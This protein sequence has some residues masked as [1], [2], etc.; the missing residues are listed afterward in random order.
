ENPNPSAAP[1]CGG[2]GEL[3]SSWNVEPGSSRRNT[4]TVSPVTPLYGSCGEPTTSAV[5]VTTTG[6]SESHGNGRFD[7]VP[8]S[9]RSNTRTGSPFTTSVRSRRATL[10][11]NIPLAVSRAVP[12]AGGSQGSPKSRRVYK[13]TLAS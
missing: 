8:S 1:D 5:S 6:P 13:N 3:G 11:A 2:R 10:S 12:L 7:Q 9:F 4:R